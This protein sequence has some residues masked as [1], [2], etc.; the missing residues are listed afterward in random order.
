MK[1]TL[2]GCYLWFLAAI[3][4]SAV[5]ASVHFVQP[6][7]GAAFNG[8]KTLDVQWVYSDSPDSQ[9]T[10][11]KFSLYLCAGG[12]EVGSYVSSSARPGFISEA[13]N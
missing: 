10:S 13:R 5:S 7:P 1:L 8:G 9:V 6:A 12:N 11:S 3:P 2:F 4:L